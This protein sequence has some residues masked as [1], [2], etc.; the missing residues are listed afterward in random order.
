MQQPLPPSTVINQ[1]TIRPPSPKLG[2]NQTGND[3][4]IVCENPNDPPIV[5]DDQMKV[6]PDGSTVHH[7]QECPV[8]EWEDPMPKI[9]PDEEVDEADD[10]D[11]P[12]PEEEDTAEE[13]NESSDSEE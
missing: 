5:C 1:I 2:D 9:I 11:Q 13:S 10:E 6:C 3:K 8:E 7:T 4:E 12:L